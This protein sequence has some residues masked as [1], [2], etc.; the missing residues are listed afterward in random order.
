MLAI[1][2]DMYVDKDMSRVD[3]VVQPERGPTQTTQVNLFPELEG[4][5]LPGTFSIIEG[6]EPGE[7]VRI[8][9]IARQDDRVRVVREAALK[10]PRRRT[11]LLSMPIQW[12]CDGHVRQEGQLHR[13]SCDEGFTCIS[14]ACQPDAID[15]ATLP[16]YEI[17]EVFGGGNA[18]GGGSCFDAL[19]CFA[20]RFEPSLDL[21]NCRLATE[22]RDDLNVAVW[23]PPGGDG[24]CTDTDCWIPL[25]RSALVGWSEADGGASVQLPPAVCERIQAGAGRVIAS[26]AC[27]SKTPGIPTCGPWTLVG[28]APGAD[29]VTGGPG[30]SLSND[31]LVAELDVATRRLASE[32]AA[33]CGG[34]A[35]LTP[36]PEPSIEDLNN[37]C[38]VARSAVAAVVPLTWYHIP[39]RCWPDQATQLECEGQ[40]APDCPAGRLEDRCLVNSLSGTCDQA[41]NTRVCLGSDATPITCTGACNGN[42]EGTC[43]G[44][45]LGECRGTCQNPGLDGL[46]DGACE[47]T[48]VGLCQGRVEGTCRG[49][50]DGDPNLA[51]EACAAGA[52][53][54]GG[55]AGEYGAVTCDGQLGPSTCALDLGCEG[56][57][58]ALAHFRVQCDR[59][60]SWIQSKPGLD[61]ALHIS[62]EGALPT[63]LNAR[64]VQTFAMFDEASRMLER[65]RA[66]S[67]SPPNVVAQLQGLIDL[68]GVIKMKATDLL[69]NV[70][71]E[72]GGPGPSNGPPG[73]ITCEALEAAGVLPLIDD[74][75]DGDSFLLPNEG[76]DGAWHLTHDRTGQLS[77]TEPPIPENGGANA[78][79]KAMHI[80][81]SGH[82]EWGG[83]LSLDLRNS[84]APYDASV[85]R[86]IKFWA[87]GNT[88]LKLIFA[89][90]NLS[91]GHPCSTC[92]L[93][94]EECGRFYTTDVLL[95]DVWREYVIDWTILGHDFQG[96]TPFGPDQLQTVQFEAPAP[97]FDFWI[98]DVTFF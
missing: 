74:L 13:S 7:F 69:A 90:A 26:T 57:C 8:R 67:G 36:P 72:R 22:A 60:R 80:S 66:D 91:P 39:T 71:A 61:P 20:S 5:F 17:E 15:E 92:V 96:G 88:S 9:V 70:G 53:C 48:C 98:D 21:A 85:Y 18:T 41:C 4:Q 2:T 50:C 37:L 79:G 59:A 6:S 40:C 83:G 78:S 56:N 11:A 64:D 1:A 62:L 55:C 42:S 95:D 75:E 86:G 28:T 51:P 81:G 31:S 3:I 23:L 82:T 63:L 94:N 25:D 54:M 33:A 10:V 77:L 43:G 14:G 44:T 47:G 84:G 87:R 12:L 16:D 49:R 46:C 52:R 89:Q 93:P 34:L 35:Q 73:A 24:H 27:A 68:L 19:E 30:E 97:A 58:R 38:D 32:V 45:C 29:V 65:M 76:R